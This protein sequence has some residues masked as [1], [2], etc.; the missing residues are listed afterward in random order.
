MISI[1]RRD[2]RPLSLRHAADL[3]QALAHP[4]RLQ[5]LDVLR[6]G[7]ATVGEIVTTLSLDQPG[8]SRHMD[9]L[10]REGIL[11]VQPRGR[12][13]VYQ[14]AACRAAPLLAALFDNDPTDTTET[15]KGNAA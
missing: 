10:R 14:L 13:R 7:D 12:E 9:I 3:L 8:V 2:C 6:E 4:I 5:I 1:D 11:S 15:D